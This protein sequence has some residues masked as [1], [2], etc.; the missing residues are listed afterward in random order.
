MNRI[1]LLFTIFMLTEC[2]LSKACKCNYPGVFAFVNQ[3]ADLVVY[4]RVIEYK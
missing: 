3:M 1:I 2:P 4:G